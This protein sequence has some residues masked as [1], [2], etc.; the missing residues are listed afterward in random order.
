ML[1]KQE[2][3]V[4]LAN[5]QLF[6]CS[7][8]IE[9]VSLAGSYRLSQSTYKSKAKNFLFDYAKRSD[10]LNSYSF[11]DYFNYQKGKSKTNQDIIPHYVGGSSIPIFSPTQEYPK[12][13][14][15]LY[16]PWK[17]TLKLG[18]ATFSKNLIIL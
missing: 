15:L 12:S 18:T 6:D 5:L 1:S 16:K 11:D 8:T 13:V 4:L 10:E 3:M 17:K 9:T 14:L 2:C 7:E